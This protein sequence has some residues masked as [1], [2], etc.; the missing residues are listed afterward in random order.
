MSLR[1]GGYVRKRKQN[2]DPEGSLP[3]ER[4]P[5]EDRVL[6]DAAWFLGKELLPLLGV[7]GKLRRAAPTEAVFL[8]ISDFLAD[9]NY[10][11][12]DG[13]W[14][15]LEFESDRISTA[16]LR[17]F[18]ACEAV[19]SYRYEVEVSTYVLCTSKTKVLRSQMS[20]GSSVYR[21]GIIRMKDYNADETIR[22]LEEK[23]KKKE[24]DREEML[25][26]LLTPLME[27]EMPQ[28]MRVRKS[29]EILQ[30]EQGRLEDRELIHMQSVL[31][32]LA[33]KF[34]TVE[35]IKQMKEMMSMTL[36]GKMLMEDG[37][38]QGIERGIEQGI[39]R[40]IEQGIA[41]G[42]FKTLH[43]LIKDGILTVREAAARKEM[44]EE[45]FQKKL[46]ELRLI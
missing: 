41:Q 16:D 20:Q 2:K 32:A 17:R 12:E 37:I 6:K 42:E 25:R 4:Y 29:L 39:E 3:K 1:E 44:S 31:Y 23:Q 11:M 38:E 7:E 13:T 46:K 10:E 19:I 40:G 22:N 34:L 24:L 35:E 26:I 5:V 36:L 27:G 28:A 33:M 9:F 14:K 21:V 18:R 45:E 30:R 43:G 8:E 15:H